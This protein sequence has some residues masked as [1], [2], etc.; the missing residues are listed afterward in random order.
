MTCGAGWG[1]EIFVWRTGGG[2]AAYRCC[3]LSIQDGAAEENESSG[4][5]NFSLTKATKLF[6]LVL[7]ARDAA[8]CTRARR[9]R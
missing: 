7:R 8:G 2:A 4:R 6:V 1:H 3:N 9:L 5:Y